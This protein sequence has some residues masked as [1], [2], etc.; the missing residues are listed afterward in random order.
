MKN[1]EKLLGTFRWLDLR[2][3]IYHVVY[4]SKM[5]N[6]E[7]YQMILFYRGVT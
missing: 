4:M 7:G 2:L 1:Y 6:F 5:A 3:K